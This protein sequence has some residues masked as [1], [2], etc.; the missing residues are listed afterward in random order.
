MVAASST[1]S[2]FTGTDRKGSYPRRRRT[3]AIYRPGSSA[4]GLCG[5]ACPRRLREDGIHRGAPL[6][7]GGPSSEPGSKGRG[8]RFLTRHRRRGANGQFSTLGS[9]LRC[10]RGPAHE[11]RIGRP[12][13]P[14]RAQAP[15]RDAV[16]GTPISIRDGARYSSGTG[17]R[18]RRLSQ[19]G[20]RSYRSAEPGQTRTWPNRFNGGG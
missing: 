8:R 7:P 1:R 5:R 3:A 19:P 12:I 17:T 16:R 15:R 11:T 2:S 10:Q 4:A 20:V 14:G 13:F 9:F 6:L 18:S